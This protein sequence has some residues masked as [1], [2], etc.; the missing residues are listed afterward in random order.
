MHKISYILV[1][2]I[3][4]IFLYTGIYGCGCNEK[5]EITEYKVNTKTMAEVK[6]IIKSKI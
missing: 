1:V 4:G 3:V 6:E 5:F 2:I